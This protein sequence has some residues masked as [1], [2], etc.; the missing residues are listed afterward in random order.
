MSNRNIPGIFG[1]MVFNDAVMKERLPKDTYRALR[2]T[3]EDGTP[4][5]LDVANVVANAIRMGGG[6]RSHAFYPLVSAH[7][8]CNRRKT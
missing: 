6:K 5:E 1:S 7:D 3:I 8:G 4:L 2:K